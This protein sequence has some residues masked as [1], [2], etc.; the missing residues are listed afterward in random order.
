MLLVGIG[1]A[2]RKLLPP[3]EIDALAQA[4]PHQKQL[5]GL[6]LV[7]E[8]FPFDHAMAVLF[9]GG[10]PGLRMPLGD[11]CDL[12]APLGQA[13]MRAGSDTG[14]VAIAPIGEVMSALGTR[15][16]MVR[17]LIGRKPFARGD[18][19]RRLIERGCMLVIG[20]DYLAGLVQAVKGRALL[21]RQLVERQM[22]DGI[23]DRLLELP[24][25]GFHRL[26][27]PCIDQVEGHAR[28]DLTRETDGFERIR[29]V[30]Q[31]AEKAQVGI[32]QCL[33]PERN[34]VDAG[35]PVA[36]KAGRLDAGGVGLHRDLDTLRHV[37]VGGDPIEDGA[38]RRGIHQRGCAT[39]H[40]NAGDRLRS[41]ECPDGFQLGEKGGDE[42]VLIHGLVAYMAVEVAVRAFRRAEGPVHINAETGFPRVGQKRE[43]PVG[44]RVRPP[45]R[46]QRRA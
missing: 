23:G 13:S 15:P 27:G 44:Q 37:P 36:V 41:G 26:L 4:K 3:G 16:R 46:F 8:L 22:I 5:V 33:D 42:A 1:I 2:T 7:I 29:H 24:L 9:D 45:G 31:S 17:H 10:K 28:K 19:L 35:S 14:I 18:F 12:R 11:G 30:M 38:D 34:A 39:A 40:E 32:V 25:P 6:G 21:D 43:G 20:Y